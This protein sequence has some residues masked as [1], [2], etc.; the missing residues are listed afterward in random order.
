MPFPPAYL[1]NS[2]PASK[3]RVS[4]ASSEKRSLNTLSVLT[5]LTPLSTALVAPATPLQAECM[6]LGI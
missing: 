5:A 4:S 2:Y 1:C 3:P 6:V